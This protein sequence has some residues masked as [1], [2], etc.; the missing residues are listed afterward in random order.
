MQRVEPKPRARISIGDSLKKP[1]LASADETSGAWARKF[2]YC[3]KSRL[4]VRATHFWPQ[5]ASRD[6]MDCAL[7]VECARCEN[8]CG[9]G[10]SWNI[11]NR[12]LR[13]FAHSSHRGANGLPHCRLTRATRS[14]F[15]A[16]T[17]P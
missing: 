12:R 13:F 11:D 10:A 4:R 3:Q 14:H 15:G 7:I 6:D 2:F 17:L 16:S 9:T 8:T 1:V 5:S